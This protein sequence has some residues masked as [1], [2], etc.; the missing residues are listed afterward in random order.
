M[1]TALDG[2]EKAVV[3]ERVVARNIKDKAALRM[4]RRRLSPYPQMGP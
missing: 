2:I 3:I 4:S 1:M